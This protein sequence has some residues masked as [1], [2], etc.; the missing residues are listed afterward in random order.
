MTEPELQ[1]AIVQTSNSAVTE[2]L[3]L[4]ISH[5]VAIPNLPSEHHVLVQVLAVALNPTDYKNPIFLPSADQ[6]AGSDF[7][8]IVTKTGS[9]VS[10]AATTGLPLGARVC[11]AVFPYNQEE[12]CG[13]TNVTSRSGAFA[14]WVV[15]DG[16]LL[17][18]VPD[19]WDDL[20]GAGLGGIGWGTAALALSDLDALGLEGMPSRRAEMKE[21]VLV[22]G[23][24]TATGTMACQMLHL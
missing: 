8:G 12:Q 20:Q 23:G 14:E 2:G 1:T 16:R 24:A 17:L 11:G 22:Y 9:L 7:C 15:A 18:R 10:N 3:P 19:H 6:G 13:E 21:P 4:V 5:C